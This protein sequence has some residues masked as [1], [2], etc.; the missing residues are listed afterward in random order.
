MAF[1]GREVTDADGLTW[2]L[3]QAVAGLGNDPE[4]QAAARVDGSA[5]VVVV[6]TPSGAA[7]SRR[8]QLPPD[9]PDMAEEELVAALAASS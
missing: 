6:C 5:D 2:T 1:D 4:K 7:R 8:L 3:I 9:W